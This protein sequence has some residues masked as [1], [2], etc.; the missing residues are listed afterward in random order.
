MLPTPTFRSLPEVSLWCCTSQIPLRSPCCIPLPSPLHFLP[1]D[2][3]H[4]HTLNP[5]SLI[6]LIQACPRTP[7]CDKSMR[8]EGR[9]QLL[10]VLLHKTLPWAQINTKNYMAAAKGK[11]LS[12]LPPHKCWSDGVSCCL[13]PS[14]GYTIQQHFVSKGLIPNEM[15]PQTGKTLTVG[16]ARKRLLLK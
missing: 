8:M 10:I 11:G 12:Q 7:P 15:S 16:K 13:V 5:L 1:I 14:T 4:R 9:I 6:R 2:S 3:L